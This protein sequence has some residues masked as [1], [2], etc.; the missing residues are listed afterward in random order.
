MTD[1][2][3]V[4]SGFTKRHAVP[5]IALSILMISCN[6]LFLRNIAKATPWQVIFSREISFSL[7][8]SCEI[9]TV[10]NSII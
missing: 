8:Y 10:I 6:G 3:D 7:M 2:H 4:S 1:I 9:W 5:I